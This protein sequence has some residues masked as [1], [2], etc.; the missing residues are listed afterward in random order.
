VSLPVIGQTVQVGDEAPNFSG[1][2][3]MQNEFSAHETANDSIIV[4]Y[5][6]GYS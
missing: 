1:T 6:M 5:F 4:L 3:I 2:T